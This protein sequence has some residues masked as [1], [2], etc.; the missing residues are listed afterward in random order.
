MVQSAYAG[1]DPEA[2]GK[3]EGADDAGVLTDPST[4]RDLRYINK[5][6]YADLHASLGGHCVY[7]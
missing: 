7:P 2:A 1:T 3:A 5:R 6:H 4:G